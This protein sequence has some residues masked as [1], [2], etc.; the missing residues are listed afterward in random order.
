MKR[1]RING[2]EYD[3]K[4]SADGTVF[5]IKADIP[6]LEPPCPGQGGDRKGLSGIRPA[7]RQADHRTGN[8]KIP[9]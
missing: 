5:L 6:L 4:L 1:I 8:R 9:H 2:L 7:Q 3:M